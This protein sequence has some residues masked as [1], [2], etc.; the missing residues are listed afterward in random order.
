MRKQHTP[1]CESGGELG[2]REMKKHKQY[3]IVTDARWLMHLSDCK[4]QIDTRLKL[5][6]VVYIISAKLRH[7]PL[8]TAMEPEP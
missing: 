2:G 8:H 1:A 3:E 6:V 5:N 7:T 4:I